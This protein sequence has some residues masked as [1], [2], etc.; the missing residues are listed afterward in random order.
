V[1]IIAPDTVL[2]T[3]SYDIVKM[4]YSGSVSEKDPA[5]GYAWLKV[6]TPGG[7]AGFVA[8]KDIRSPLDQRA[9]FERRAGGWILTVL[10]SGD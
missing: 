3:L 5:D 7:K 1:S 8:R 10:V 2:E 6:Q 4:D 9:C